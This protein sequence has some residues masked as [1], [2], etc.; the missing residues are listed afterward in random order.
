M[1]YNNQGKIVKVDAN[2]GLIKWQ[3]RVSNDLIGMPVLF[4]EGCSRVSSQ[5]I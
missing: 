5:K 2:D 3:K 1:I 4:K